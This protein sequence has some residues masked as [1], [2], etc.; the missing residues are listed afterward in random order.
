MAGVSQYVTVQ[1]MLTAPLGVSLR[2]VSA[3]G[4]TGAT[5]V[6]GQQTY[7]ELQFVAQRASALAD[8]YCMQVLGATLDTEEKWTG[9]GLAWVD[10]NGYLNVHTDYWPIL[11]VQ[12][13][14]Y[15]Y[16]MLGSITWTVPLLTDL[17]TLRER[18]VYPIFLAQRG[19]PPMRVQY[20]YLNG[21]PNTTLTTAIAAGVTALPVADA[22]GMVAGGKLT[23][24]DEGNTE[25]VTIASS[26]VPVQG[27]ASV[28]LAAATAF[29][30]TPIF[31]PAT[32]PA[33]PY[34][35]AVSA[36]PADVKQAVL[37]IVKELLEV[38]GAN[39]LVMGRAGG[40][41]GSTTKGTASAEKVPIESQFVLDRYRR[42]L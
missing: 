26:W 13:F 30:H 21:W 3:K 6:T 22:T 18:I 42:T 38:R 32:P 12:S 5:G 20:T 4:S 34:D 11:S 23:I 16:P 8:N 15:S 39:S 9:S 25:Q 14:Q 24:Y 28:T 17:V 40:V 10:V 37:L 19:I 31:R 29:A 33:Q 35:I 7:E 2:N 36:L 41:S 1:E 27:A